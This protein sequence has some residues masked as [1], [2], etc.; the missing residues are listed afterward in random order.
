MEAIRQNILLRIGLIPP[1]QR[2]KILREYDTWLYR[3]RSVLSTK[4]NIFGVFSHG[5]QN[6]IGHFLVSYTLLVL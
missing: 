2:A 5:L 1:H 6:S 3:E 4:S